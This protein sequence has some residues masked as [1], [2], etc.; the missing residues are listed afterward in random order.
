L[1]AVAGTVI[2]QAWPGDC[3][4]VIWAFTLASG[5]PAQYTFTQSPQQLLSGD[6]DTVIPV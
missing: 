2:P 4:D 3:F 1:P 5:T 6:A